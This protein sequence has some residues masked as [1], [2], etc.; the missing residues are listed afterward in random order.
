MDGLLWNLELLRITHY[1]ICWY[2][3]CLHT[4]KLC[5]GL[6]SS[7]VMETH[8]QQ[9]DISIGTAIYMDNRMFS[10]VTAQLRI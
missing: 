1:A 8:Y 5:S 7:I 10:Y 9:K 2:V 3:V 4:N 6:S